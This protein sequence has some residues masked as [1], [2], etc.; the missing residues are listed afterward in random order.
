MSE[1]QDKQEKQ[2]WFNVNYLGLILVL[3]ATAVSLIKVYTAAQETTNPNEI[4]IRIAHWQLEQGYRDAMNDII[5]FYQLEVNGAYADPKYNDPA[6]IPTDALEK[7]KWLKK[8]KYKGPYKFEKPVR[9]LQMGVTERVYPQWVNTR[10]ISRDAPDL[11]EIGKG[12]MAKDEEYLARF[13]TSVT[14]Q[15]SRPNPYN[16][17]HKLDDGTEL[18]E[19][20][21]RDTLLDGNRQG[22]KQ[23]VQEYLAIPT[24]MYPTRLYVNMKVLR[25]A[26]RLLAA[27]E[28]KHGEHD[29]ENRLEAVGWS[30]RVVLERDA[31]GKVTK[32]RPAQAADYDSGVELQVLTPRTFGQLILVCERMS[33]MEL[34]GDGSYRTLD[35]PDARSRYRLVP[36]AGSAYGVTG[37]FLKRYAVA[38][39]SEYLPD[40][41]TSLDG[42]L[43]APENYVAFRRG[44]VSMEDERIREYW[45]CIRELC[46]QF[47]PGFF[48]QDRQGADFSFAQGM[49]GIIFNGS[50]QASFYI[51]AG[52]EN[53]FEVEIIDFPLPGPGEP[54][55]EYVMSEF[56]GIVSKASEAKMSGGGLYGVYKFSRHPEVAIDFMQFIT[57]KPWNQKFTSRAEL[58]PIAVGAKPIEY[59]KAFMPDPVGFDDA[60]RW[61]IGNDT[62]QDVGGKMQNEQWP[63][64]QGNIQQ[65]LYKDKYTAIL[66]NRLEQAKQQFSGDELMLEE[67][68]IREEI[69]RQVEDE[70]YEEF[71]KSYIAKLTDENK[72]AQD[73]MQQTVKKNIQLCRSQETQLAAYELQR[74]MPE[75]MVEVETGGEEA[76]ADVIA[77]R[78]Y[79]KYRKI[80]LQQVIRNNGEGDRA[81]YRKLFPDAPEIK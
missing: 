79:N 25:E 9:V 45:R 12:A 51:Q 58:L 49:A 13:F 6:N 16:K 66:D 19:I 24:T 31:A 3:G 1:K 59:M 67:A 77:E 72:G 28:I 47:G 55:R 36:I 75:A 53:G 78:S 61:N 71:A 56:P 70:A 48:A 29:G 20:P 80:L 76:D 73:A 69:D 68:R 57:S 18:D 63:F 23:K 40:F 64:L 42:N 35:D 43:N 27:E 11:I 30:D 33:R 46:K 32:W 15:M 44:Q 65:R 74:L 41:D 8:V 21:W 5:E 62:W 39:Q 34:Q 22:F 37:E 14:D 2:G 10:L 54:F 81:K 17:G 26:K 60:A 38:F 7:G 52:K 4:Y 50:W